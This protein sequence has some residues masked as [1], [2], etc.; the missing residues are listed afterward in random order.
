MRYNINYNLVT[1]YF[2]N[3][4]FLNLNLTVICHFKVTFHT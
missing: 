4:N 1:Y 3:F 2:I